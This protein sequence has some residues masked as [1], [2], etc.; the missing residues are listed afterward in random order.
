MELISKHQEKKA[1]K[2][3]KLCKLKVIFCF[4]IF[5]SCLYTPAKS[6]IAMNIDN[7]M[8]AGSFSSDISSLLNWAE[9]QVAITISNNTPIGLDFYLEFEVTRNGQTAF[10]TT[11]SDG[12]ENGDQQ[13]MIEQL[14]IE[15]LSTRTF[16]SS[17][18]EEA[19]PFLNGDLGLIQDYLLIVDPD[20]EDLGALYLNGVLP[21]GEYGICATAVF[22]NEEEATT[23]ELSEP[24]CSIGGNLFA[25]ITQPPRLINPLNE[26]T[27][28]ANPNS[29]IFITWEHI[30]ASNTIFDYA[31]KIMEIPEDQDDLEELMNSQTTFDLVAYVQNINQLSYLYPGDGSE[32]DLEVGKEYAIQVQAFSSE[33]I[34]PLQNNGRSEIHR[35]IYGENIVDIGDAEVDEDGNIV[36]DCDCFLD[37]RNMEETNTELSVGDSI[38]VGKFFM[39]ISSVNNRRGAGTIEVP[40]FGNTKVK[41]DFRNL[42]TTADKKMTSGTVK[43][44]YHDNWLN[45]DATYNEDDGF[46]LAYMDV[47][48]D[49]IKTVNVLRTLDDGMTLPF[50]VDLGYNEYKFKLGINSLEFTPTHANISVLLTVPQLLPISGMDKSIAFGTNACLNPEGFASRAMLILGDEF[51]VMTM[52]EEMDID[53]DHPLYGVT[54]NLAGKS[55]IDDVEKARD[56]VCFVEFDCNGLKGLGL[57]GDI[58]IPKSLLVVE[59][60]ENGE[61]NLDQFVKGTFDFVMDIDGGGIST[62]NTDLEEIAAQ[63]ATGET[64]F[65]ILLGLEFT[66][67]QLQ[68]LEG[69]GFHATEAYLDLSETENAFTSKTPPSKCSNPELDSTV[70]YD[71]T[72]KGIYIKSAQ[73]RLPNDFLGIEGRAEFGID[74]LLIG[75][76]GVSASFYVET[77]GLIDF[78][79]TSESDS[80]SGF[81]F[82]MDKVYLCMQQSALQ[83]AGIEGKI[84]VPLFEK[85]DRLEYTMAID[86][87]E[88]LEDTLAYVL[89]VKV[90]NEPVGIP[91]FIAE[92]ELNSSTHLKMRY[93]HAIS[94]NSDSEEEEGEESSFFDD[95][96]I[97]LVLAGKLNLS[98]DFIEANELRPEADVKLPEIPFEIKYNTE[99]GFGASSKFML[100]GSQNNNSNNTNPGA[101]VVKKPSVAGFSVNVNEFKLGGTATSPSLTIGAGL[102]LASS[103]SSL[104]LNANLTVKGR[105]TNDGLRLASANLNCLGMD[106]YMSG[107]GIKGELCFYK[108]T[109]QAIRYQGIYGNLSVGLPV[110]GARFDMDGTFG[111]AVTDEDANWNTVDNYNYFYVDAGLVLNPGIPMG[112]QF[113][114]LYGLEGGVRLNMEKI[115]INPLTGERVAINDAGQEVEP[116]P[117][118]EIPGNRTLK[119]VPKFGNFGLGF[120]MTLGAARPDPFLAKLY[121]EGEF[122]LANGGIRNLAATGTGYIM[123]VN[124]NLDLSPMW[125]DISSDLTFQQFPNQWSLLLDGSAYVKFPVGAPPILYGNDGGAVHRAGNIYFYMDNYSNGPGNMK[126]TVRSGSFGRTQA[127]WMPNRLSLNLE[128]YNLDIGSVDLESYFWFGPDV[129]TY[130]PPKPQAVLNLI[131]YKNEGNGGSFSTDASNGI[132]GGSSTG[133]GIAHGTR[134]N[135]DLGIDALLVYGEFASTIGYDLNL[136]QS[137]GRSCGSIENIGIEGWY[138]QGSGYAGVQ[139]DVGVKFPRWIRNVLQDAANVANGVSNAG[140]SI[141]NVFTGDDTED[142]DITIEEKMKLFF[143]RA[144]VLMDAGAPAPVWATG[145]GFLDLDID[146]AITTWKQNLSFDFIFG[147]PCIQTTENPFESSNLISSMIPGEEA[148][149]NYDMIPTVVLNYPLNQNF[150]YQ[151]I[152][153]DGTKE[154]KSFR[155]ALESYTLRT[156]AG[157]NIE[158]AT[159]ISDDKRTIRF[160][161]ISS[162]TP[163]AAYDIEVTFSGRE[164]SNSIISERRSESFTVAEKLGMTAEDVKG[165]FPFVDQKFL[166]VNEVVGQ[167][168]KLIFDSS[169]AELSFMNALEYQVTI[170]T[171]DQ[172]QVFEIRATYNNGQIT[173]NLPQLSSSNN[174]S[175]EFASRK[176]MNTIVQGNF[177]FFGTNLSALYGSMSQLESLDEERP[178]EKFY[179]YS[180]ST[181]KY[182]T[183]EDKISALQVIVKNNPNVNNLFNLNI[184]GTKK[185]GKVSKGNMSAVNNP[186]K[187]ELVGTELFE[188]KEI[189]GTDF[190]PPLI[191]ISDPLAGNAY[192]DA[193]KNKFEFLEEVPTS[194]I[195]ITSKINKT[196][197]F[198]IGRLSREG[199]IKNMLISREGSN[200][201]GMKLD[202]GTPNNYYNIIN[203]PSDNNGIYNLGNLN[204]SNLNLGTPNLQVTNDQSYNLKEKISG[205]GK[206]TIEKK[207]KLEKMTI[208]YHPEHYLSSHKISV[209]NWLADAIS[210]QPIYLNLRV[211]DPL[212]S[213]ELAPK[214]IELENME[215]SI[216]FDKSGPLL[217]FTYYHSGEFIS[218]TSKS[219]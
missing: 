134:F 191:K 85:D 99:K 103:S 61:R 137:F 18:L 157:T 16:S 27:I 213:E 24:S 88:I 92:A 83:T 114:F 200:Q 97:D 156:K 105:V 168:G 163:G 53:P 48:L 8:L 58:T 184:G 50:G 65:D 143:L 74:D 204:F 149:V 73:L 39:T 98:T 67:F 34:S 189:Y 55:K 178:Y 159:E 148:D 195:S 37:L 72:W 52:N 210:L 128:N 6:Q 9:S 104:G 21:E 111:S 102:N 44:K 96:E 112:Q 183:L 54:I 169:I 51:S 176:K 11:F 64:N 75:E 175:I 197:Y 93:A 1:M 162:F 170:K 187:L 209:L 193:L 181:S 142:T 7:V 123:P 151:T 164:G 214:Y 145:K 177:S 217:R 167:K 60:P 150:E 33:D 117:P 45:A 71:E 196:V 179:N 31:I 185:K 194:T 79:T 173:Y 47:F 42:K 129:P 107:V 211:N 87:S 203:P 15:G 19:Y 190:F 132:S 10:F 192:Y 78:D 218:Q 46:N 68:I 126:W 101:G 108:T 154:I 82:S 138:G 69:W 188:T 35:F 118:I 202:L 172:S 133:F 25:E 207:T 80:T 89:D 38:Q 26:T 130:L 215:T 94:G 216:Q 125:F 201:R 153:A 158:T 212:F 5:L 219:Y 182:T 140:A 95:L 56:E 86:V 28:F 57:R 115:K 29:E 91:I 180:F 4:V 81:A 208:D 160:I 20:F 12:I 84:G 113:I 171:A 131:N 119:Y 106:A 40:A 127:D 199:T 121:V 205:I 122:D 63:E 41:V 76:E 155:V 141:W 206:K 90:G 59:N 147:T 152:K 2:F 22:I 49:F 166:L 23:F 70:V 186:Y 43:A 135:I 17:D 110:V 3:L 116:S 30:S 146:L 198:G 174:Y 120:G 136:T 165:A 77:A 36:D 144:L 109:E 13:L 32:N 14:T 139:G 66:P 124:G 62:G 161:P 100:P